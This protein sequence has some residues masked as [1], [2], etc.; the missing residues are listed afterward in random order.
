MENPPLDERR[1]LRIASKL[2]AVTVCTVLSFALIEVGLRLFTT[3]SQVGPTF[4]TYSDLMSFENKKNL[5][6]TRTAPEYRHRVHTNSLGQ[7][8]GPVDVEKRPGSKRVLCVGD[9]RTFGKGVEDDEPF[10]NILAARFQPSERGLTYEFLNTGVVSHSTANQYLY[11]KEQGLALRPDLIVYQISRNDFR[12]NRKG[13]VFEI[14]DEGRLQRG[15]PNLKMRRLVHLF[16]S[17]PFRSLF[18]YSYF[19][20][21]FRRQFQILIGAE[22]FERGAPESTAESKREQIAYERELT[23][24]LLDET[25]S[26]TTDAGVPLLVLTTDLEPEEQAIVQRIRTKHGALAL[27][28][29]GFRDL[30]PELLYPPGG[31]WTAQD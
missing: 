18:E 16:E 3:P 12:E 26:L 25:M 23:K 19:F 31:H 24:R 27:R 6:C 9:S 21:S 4:T 8:N 17:I 11:L 29:D 15:P 30:R 1:S 14:D 10:C 20:N 13:R 2:I 5:D 7:R 28:L 22:F